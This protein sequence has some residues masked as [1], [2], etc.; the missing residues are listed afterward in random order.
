MP[1]AISAVT[2]RCHGAGDSIMFG[3]GN[4]PTP[5]GILYPVA[6]DIWYQQ[7]ALAAPAYGWKPSGSTATVTLMP[8]T[9]DGISGSTLQDLATSRVARIGAYNPTKLFID[10]SPNDWAGALPGSWTTPANTILSYW[11]GTLGRAAS[12]M[13]MISTV[14]SLGEQWQA[15][16][17]A[18]WG[19]NPSDA[20]LATLNGIASSWCA[21]N[22]VYYM[23]IRGTYTTDPNTAAQ[24]ESLNNGVAPGSANGPISNPASPIHP[25]ITK[26]QKIVASF[27]SANL[28][29]T[30]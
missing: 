30:Y 2:D 1:F 25:S 3:Q 7:M 26:G 12:D 27:I 29:V 5:G 18:C 17:A 14:L 23:D 11:T 16:P 10:V 6:Q 24:Y 19:L 15:A 21:S 8:F 28:S 20:A 4:S 22:G 13:C 9:Q